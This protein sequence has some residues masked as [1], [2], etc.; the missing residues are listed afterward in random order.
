MGVSMK[1]LI[2]CLFMG[3]VM[4]PSTNCRA[5]AASLSAIQDQAGFYRVCYLNNVTLKQTEA[6]KLADE[7]L[8]SGYLN[9][10][11]NGWRDGHGHGVL[12]AHF[13]GAFPAD[14]S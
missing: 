3:L 10:L 7:S 13:P 5:Q 9:G 12:A 2:G 6:Q 8:C 14:E 1:A 11:I 4:G